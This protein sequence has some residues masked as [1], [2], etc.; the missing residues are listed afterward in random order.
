MKEKKLWKK[1]RRAKNK[2]VKWITNDPKS[3][4]LKEVIFTG[5]QAG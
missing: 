2:K 3:Q 4:P 5:D 1:R